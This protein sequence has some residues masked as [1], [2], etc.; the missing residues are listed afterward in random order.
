MVNKETVYDS[1]QPAQDRMGY[2]VV[3]EYVN[4][5]RSTGRRSAHTVINYE[6]DL[7]L[8]LQYLEE[9]GYEIPDNRA[10][11]PLGVVDPLALRGFITYLLDRGNSAR[12]INR[13]LSALRSFFDYWVRRGRL[14][15]NPTQTLH[16]LKAPKRLPVF[17]DQERAGDLMEHPNENLVHDKALLLRDRAMLELLYSTGMRVS[18]LAGI[19]L[20]D[21][22]LQGRSV[23]ILA[24]RGKDLTLPVGEAAVEALK[25]YLDARPAL[26]NRPSR[27]RHPKD[28]NALFLGR[29]GERLTPRGVQLRLRRYALSLGLG[30][31]TPHTL[32]H[33]CATHLLE[34]G[35]DL[36]FVQELLGHSSL[37]TTQ[38]YTHVTLSRIQAVYQKSHPRAGDRQKPPKKQG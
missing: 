5:L 9:S 26:L 28:P 30:K 35:A 27:S 21:L 4:Y 29:F 18:S 22:D 38:Q 14:E 15:S 20:N 25:P 37:A 31:T 3:Q 12:S 23:R 10:D 8:L 1:K 32:R 11:Y 16:F 36:R 7:R 13:R 33:S 6:R 17:L 2:P 34:N 24:K 19:N